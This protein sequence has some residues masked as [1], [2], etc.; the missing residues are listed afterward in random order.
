MKEG[1]V[2]I[3]DEDKA[4][5]LLSQV[6]WFSQAS[7]SPILFWCFVLFF[8]GFWPCFKIKKSFHFSRVCINCD[9]ANFLK[10]EVDDLRAEANQ[11]EA[12]G[13]QWIECAVAVLKAE[14]LYDLLQGDV[15]W[16]EL[17]VTVACPCLK[18]SGFPQLQFLA[19]QPKSQR[20]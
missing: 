13:L 6:F 12:K 2:P 17:S 5:G 8:L 7:S 1:G 11:L 3:A 10:Q 19:W 18:E 9:W 15:A 14:G 20:L 4:Q 16:P